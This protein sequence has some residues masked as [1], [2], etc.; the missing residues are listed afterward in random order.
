MLMELAELYELDYRLVAEWAGYL[1]PR[2]PRVSSNLAGM[3]LRLFVEL[4]APAQHE[5][6]AYLERLRNDHLHPERSGTPQ[7]EMPGKP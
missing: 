3:V 7:I 5:A 6:L 1:G 2:A 4:D